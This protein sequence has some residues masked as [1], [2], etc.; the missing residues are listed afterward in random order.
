MNKLN[1]G[2]LRL[3]SDEILEKSQLASV[4]GGAQF[5]CYCGFVGGC[6]ESYPFPVSASNLTR[7]LEKAAD[8]CHVLGA[9]CTGSN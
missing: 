7:A 5:T 4:Y 2:K 3:H 8:D 6:G 9:T 1:L